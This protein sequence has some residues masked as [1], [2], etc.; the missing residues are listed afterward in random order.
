MKI[1]KIMKININELK[2]TCTGAVKYQIF[3]TRKQFIIDV[4]IMCCD[5]T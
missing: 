5:R 4:Y 2:S 3:Y 1:R